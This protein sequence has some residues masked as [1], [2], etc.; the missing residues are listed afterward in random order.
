MNETALA[1]DCQGTP[2]VGILHRPERPAARGIVMVVGG[3]PQY[4]AGGHRQMTLWARHLAREGYPVFRFDYRGM[5][6]SHGEFKGFEAVDDDIQAAI[7]QFVGSEPTLQEIILWGECDAASAIL[8]YAYR[9]P[10][11]R[12]LVLLNPWA[13]TEVGQ[14]RTILRHYYFSRL[15]EPEF[16][17]KLLSLRLDIHASLRTLTRN[18]L[19]GLKTHTNPEPPTDPAAP[20]SRKSPLPDRLLAGFSRFQG[21]VFLVMSGRDLIAREFDEVIRAKSQHWEAQFRAKPCLRH[22]M[23]EGDHTFSSAALREEVITH[24]L[25]WLASFTP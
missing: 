24:A 15:A 8:F 7:D 22:D 13:R 10:R 17:R 19:L 6:D 23:P 5:G 9:D 14:A 2:L 3:G 16:W 20:L 12:G 11:V 21:P 18:V 1:F 25:A 4:R